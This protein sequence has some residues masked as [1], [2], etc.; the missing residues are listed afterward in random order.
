MVSAL[1]DNFQLSRST[2]LMTRILAVGSH[3]RRLTNISRRWP[4]GLVWIA[5]ISVPFFRISAVSRR[6]I[7]GLYEAGR[8]DQD[9]CSP[10]Y[11]SNIGPV[12]RLCDKTGSANP[13]T[14]SQ[15][16][17]SNRNTCRRFHES[18]PCRK[19]YAR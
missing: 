12:A 7:S 8:T 14:R 11:R 19:S 6:L 1:T 5:E 13:C 16:H 18:S 9:F 3:L 17:E 15:A 4:P 2:A 10:D